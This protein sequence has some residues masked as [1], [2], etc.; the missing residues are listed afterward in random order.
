MNRSL[1][2][3]TIALLVA[4]LV[5]TC[6]FVVKETE[7]AVVLKFGEVV[8][9]DVEPGIHWKIPFVHT[10]RRFDGRILTMDARAERYLTLEKKALSSVSFLPCS[11][12]MT[13]GS[14]AS[15]VVAPAACAFSRQHTR[16][17][18][19]PAVFTRKE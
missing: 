11:V 7:R 17:R 18:T 6:V 10:V 16:T 1:L 19:A 4:L 8:R 5:S 14:W 3:V 13:S 9:P 15:R 12:R 2:S